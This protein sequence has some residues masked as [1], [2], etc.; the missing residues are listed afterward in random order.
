VAIAAVAGIAVLVVSRQDDGDTSP[1]V[2]EVAQKPAR[3]ER[4]AG[5]KADDSLRL[6]EALTLDSA[7]LHRAE[8]KSAVPADAFGR[9]SW[10]VPPP[11]PPPVIMPPPPPPPPPTAPPLPFTFMGRYMESNKPVF[12]LT[13]GD[14]LLM[15]HAGDVID[16]TYRVEG[17]VGNKLDITYLPLN[18]KQSLDAGSSG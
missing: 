14:R 3:S 11:P 17:L 10:Y 6:A 9:H 2:S 16:G 13:A 7:A 1:A 8:D 5:R 15:V 12:F 4:A 18:I